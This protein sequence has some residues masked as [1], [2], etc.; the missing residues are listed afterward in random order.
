MPE[1][2]TIQDIAR[3]AGVSKATV[4]RVLNHKPDVDRQTRQH[5]LQIM[6]EHAFVPS[7]T[8]SGLAGGRRGMIGILVPA[9]TWHFIPEVVQGAAE[10]IEQSAYELLL[11]SIA[12]G[13]NRKAVLDRILDTKLTAGLLSV[14]PGAFVERLA[15]W[16]D[17]GF[18]VVLIDDQH[19]PSDTPGIS[20]DNR[21]GALAAVRHLMG[22]GHR[23]IAYMQG[24]LQYQCSQERYEGYQQAIAEAG[25]SMNPA[26]VVEGDFSV[27]SGFT[28]ASE[29]M[30]LDGERPTAIFAANDHMAWGVLEFAQE[31][32]LSVPEDIAV[33]GFDDTP[34]SQYKQPPLTTVR[35]PFQ[36]MGKRA[37]ELL[38]WLIDLSRNSADERR[39]PPA[40]APPSPIRGYTPPLHIQ[41]ETSLV[42]RQSCGAHQ[43]TSINSR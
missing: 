29:L 8:A 38:L 23:R 40:F 19:V 1:R 21:R 13:E 9:L 34:P 22:L 10:V 16:Y 30:T 35:Q 6:D 17:E 15:Q 43:V 27:A 3:L 18:P 25:L 24:P 31:Y 20:V 11:Y 4:S 33:V 2:L 41:L 39:R 26:Y 28:C 14:A 36:E 7:I 12:P 5:V 42:V 37:A 32:G